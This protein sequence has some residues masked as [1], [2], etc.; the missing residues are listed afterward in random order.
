MLLGVLTREHT[1]NKDMYGSF[2]V[3]AQSRNATEFSRI[4]LQQL[5]IR[6]VKRGVFDRFSLF[7]MVNLTYNFF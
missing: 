7:T 4:Q 5:T 1:M 6:D 3:A 2:T